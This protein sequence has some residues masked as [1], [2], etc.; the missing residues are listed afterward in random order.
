MS[1][2][3]YGP[4]IQQAK[5][6]VNLAA[7]LDEAP[8]LAVG[9]ESFTL[10]QLN[11]DKD[12][13]SPVRIRAMLDFHFA[14]DGRVLWAQSPSEAKTAITDARLRLWG[15]YESGPDH[16][17]DAMKHCLL[18]AKKVRGRSREEIVAVHGNEM[19]WWEEEGRG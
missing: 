8:G 3:L 19:E 7:L 15:L 11:M 10:Q 2:Y 13:L 16:I 9:V 17:R 12:L 6:Y 1:G 5:A 14:L 4:E 18:W